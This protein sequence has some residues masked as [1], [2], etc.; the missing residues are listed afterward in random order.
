MAVPVMAAFAVI[1]WWVFFHKGLASAAYD[2]F[3][4]PGLLILVFAITVVSAGF[5]E[6][7]Y[8]AAARYGGATPGVMGFGV[9][10]VCHA[11][12]WTK[13]GSSQSTSR[14]RLSQGTT[15]RWR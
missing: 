15:R 13:A 9:Y 4:R 11:L 6:F 12:R 14:W 1:C 2:A 7:G 8:A 10:L 3:E 5:H